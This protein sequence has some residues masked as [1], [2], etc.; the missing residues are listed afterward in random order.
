MVVLD[1]YQVKYFARLLLLLALMVI[2]VGCSSKSGTSEKLSNS[3]DSKT[4][5]TTNSK[6]GTPQKGG[7]V[8]IAYYTD[9]TNYDPIQGSGGSD[10]ALLWPVFDTLISFT[11]ELE[12]LPGLAESWDFPDDKTLVLHL[13]EGVT[14]HDGTRFDAEAVKFNLERNNSEESKVA[15]LE[16]IESVEVVDPKTVKLNLKQADSSLLLALSDR[17][18]MI[19]SPTA[20]KESGEDYS[21]KPVGAGPFKMVNRIPNGE[22]VFEAFEDYWQEGKPYLDK[23]TVKVMA[24]ENTRINALKSGEID[25]ADTISAGNVPNIENSSNLVLKDILPV[26]FRIIYLNSSMAPFDNKAVRLA[27]QHGINREALIEGINFGKGEPATQVFPKE[28]WAAD[29]DMTIEYDPEKSKQ[30]LKEAGLENVSFT[31]IQN[32]NAQD[33]K[34]AE[35]IKGQLKEVGI[36]VD[37]QA[38]EIN[39]ATASYFSEKKAPALYSAWTG[40]PDPQMTINYLFSKDSFFNTGGYSTEEIESLIS[41]AAS[42]YD[43]AERI[44]LYKEISKQALLE[45]AIAI[46]VIF[47]PITSAMNEKVKGFEPNMIGKPIYSNIW[48]DE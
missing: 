47:E 19:V 17:G 38:M 12:P 24:D 32:A 3:N 13:R 22:I 2:I 10:H 18:G 48:M 7:E 43:Q 45:E 35:A 6:K 5:E 40:R 20:V 1:K 28:Y 29:K 8:V 15:D 26:R 42:S 9:V 23:M 31:L 37:I 27:V 14:F 46:P 33:A 16:N 34:M 11:P 36:D 41:E 25:Y 39:T 4:E 30:L 21:Q 44:K